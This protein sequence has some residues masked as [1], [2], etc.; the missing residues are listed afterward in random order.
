MTPKQA[1]DLQDELASCL[2]ESLVHQLQCNIAAIFQAQPDGDGDLVTS[3]G[4]LTMGRIL[5]FVNKELDAPDSPYDEDTQAQE[6]PL[7]V[8][9]CI[10]CGEPGHYDCSEDYTAAER[11]E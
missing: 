9:L 4:A 2:L 8:D 10:N 7:H 11:F 1:K 6:I 5:N 3:E